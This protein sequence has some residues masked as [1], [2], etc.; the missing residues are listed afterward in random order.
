MNN[1][2]L[3][4]SLNAELFIVKLGTFLSFVCVIIHQSLEVSAKHQ[5]LARSVGAILI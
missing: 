5:I 1:S 3:N 4:N 2:L